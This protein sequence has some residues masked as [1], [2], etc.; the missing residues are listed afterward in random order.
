MFKTR[1][2]GKIFGV[3]VKLHGTFLILLAFTAVSGLLQ[4]GFVQALLSL[5]L[6]VIIFGVV[7]CHEFGHILAARKYGIKTKDVILSPI[8]GMARLQGMPGTPKQEMVVAAAGPAVNLALAGLGFLLLAVPG[9]S[10]TTTASAFFASL[11]SWFIT[12]N[13]VLL[14]FN[15]IPALPMDGGRILRALLTK[16]YGYLKA[17]QK[18]ARVA[19][20]SAGLMAVYAVFTGQFMLLLIAGFVFAMS[21]MELWQAKVAQAQRDPIF[22]FA[23][24]FGKAPQGAA[25]SQ[26]SGYSQVVDQDGNPVNAPSDGWQVKNVRWV[27]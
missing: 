24:A 19:R 7:V 5:A 22:R 13:L 12:I 6:A 9:L 25:P 23:Q 18:A 26:S 1:S 14:G 15:L 4:G 8:G 16:K 17:T 27:K 11:L 2:L 3:E 21:W 20:W 10:F